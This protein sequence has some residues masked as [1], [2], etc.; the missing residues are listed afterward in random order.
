MHK[1]NK[2]EL[3]SHTLFWL[4]LVVV[5]ISWVSLLFVTYIFPQCQNHPLLSFN[6]TTLIQWFI[7]HVL[8]SHVNLSPCLS[9]LLSAPTSGLVWQWGVLSL[10][11][12]VLQDWKFC[13]FLLSLLNRTFC[14]PLS[15]CLFFINLF[16]IT[17]RKGA[18]TEEKYYF[19]S[20]I[21]IWNCWCKIDD[22]KWG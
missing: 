2:E 1:F 13:S 20:H 4:L 8:S 3:Y 17:R 14:R 7:F 11:S 19:K 9:A 5:A 21:I 18:H 22:G 6:I 10:F 12:V 15:H 16:T